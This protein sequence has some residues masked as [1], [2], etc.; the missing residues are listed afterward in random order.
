ML[1]DQVEQF[2]D[3]VVDLVVGTTFRFTTLFDISIRI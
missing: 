2:V 1:A 3:E